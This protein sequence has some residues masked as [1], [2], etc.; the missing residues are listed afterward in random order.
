MSTHNIFLQRTLDNFLQ[1]CKKNKHI[2]VES[3]LGKFRIWE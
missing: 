3:D 2:V 1:L